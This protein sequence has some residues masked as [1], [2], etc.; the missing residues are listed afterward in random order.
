MKPLLLLYLTGQLFCCLCKSEKDGRGCQDPSEASLCLHIRSK[1]AMRNAH[2]VCSCWTAARC[3]EGAEPSTSFLRFLSPLLLSCLKPPH[4]APRRPQ[5]SNTT[6]P[7]LHPAPQFHRHRLRQ[8][9]VAGLV[10]DPI[11]NSQATLRDSGKIGETGGRVTRVPT[12]VQACTR[13]HT[14]AHACTRRTRPALRWKPKIGWRRICL[15]ARVGF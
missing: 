10:G 7:V 8:S 3:R 2:A 4:R 6:S 12:H 1:W 13:M 9:F 11:S 5:R 15:Q 14:H